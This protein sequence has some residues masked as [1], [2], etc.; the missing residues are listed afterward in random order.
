MSE[1]TKLD[2]IKKKGENS[3]LFVQQEKKKKRLRREITIVCTF[4][5][6][7]PVRKKV[8]DGVCED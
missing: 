4:L 7:T 2:V 8:S 6:N 3:H 1:N 5:V